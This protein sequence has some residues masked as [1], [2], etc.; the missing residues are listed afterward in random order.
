VAIRFRNRKGSFGQTSSALSGVTAAVLGAYTP[1]SQRIGQLAAAIGQLAASMRGRYVVNSEYSGSLSAS[2][3][4]AAAA[5][6]GVFQS[7]GNPPLWTDN[8]GDFFSVEPNTAFSYTFTASDAD[9]DPIVFSYAVPPAGIVI[10]EHPQVGNSRSVTVSSAGLPVPSPPAIPDSY[11][12]AIDSLDITTDDIAQVTVVASEA[13]AWTIGHAFAENDAPHYVTANADAVQVDVLNRWPNNSV[14]FALISAIS[15]PGTITIQA[16]SA[17]PTGPLV[18]EIEA[19]DVGETGVTID[20]EFVSLGAAIAGA[21]LIGYAGPPGV[22][23]PQPGKFRDRISGHVMRESHY[24]A[25]V[26]SKTGLAVIWYVRKYANG[27]VEVDTAVENG[28]FGFAAQNQ[29][30]TA[31][32]TVNGT[33]RAWHDGVLSRSIVHT[34]HSRWSRVD[35]AGSQTT[36]EVLHDTQYLMSTRLTPNY[37]WEVPTSEAAFTA[38]NH[39]RT[40]GSVTADEANAPTPMDRTFWRPAQAAGGENICDQIGLLPSWEGVYLRTGDPRARHAVLLGGR[41]WQQWIQTWRRDERT[42]ALPRFDDVSRFERLTTNEEREHQPSTGYLSYLLTGR[43]YFLETQQNMAEFN[44]FTAPPLNP[45]PENESGG[46]GVG[47]RRGIVSSNVYSTRGVAWPLRNFAN[48]L[49]IT[50]DADP[51]REDL[52]LGWVNTMDYYWGLQRD[53][54]AMKN[55]LGVVWTTSCDTFYS[56]GTNIDADPTTIVFPSGG[57]P[58]YAVLYD[59]TPA[60]KNLLGYVIL[61]GAEVGVGGSIQIDLNSTTSTTWK[62]YL[63][64][65][66]RVVDGTIN[67]HS[68][69]FKYCV[70]TSSYV[71]STS[72][73]T[74]AD[75]SAYRVAGTADTTLANFGYDPLNGAACGFGYL[76]TLDPATQQEG[77]PVPGRPLVNL[78]R[79]GAWQHSFMSATLGL[80]RG[81]KLVIGQAQSD[82]EELHAFSVQFPI[83]RMG[84]TYD[85]SGFSWLRC[86]TYYEPVGISSIPY[87][88]QSLLNPPASFFPSWRACYEFNRDYWGALD[89]DDSDTTQPIFCSWGNS[90]GASLPGFDPSPTPETIDTSN[91]ITSLPRLVPTRSMVMSLALG[92]DYSVPGAREAYDKL[93]NSGVYS[94]DATARQNL[95][96]APRYMVTPR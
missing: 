39:G 51:L 45:W 4:G 60:G 48:A 3:S 18:A 74:L 23:P 16:A 44:F 92:A 35:W 90:V 85:N 87:P 94:D 61:S 13:A 68:D 83:G 33:V 63:A 71:P 40:I 84:F 1:A 38:D 12:V 22:R 36:A 95:A 20:G 19:G 57:A 6:R 9:S 28:W 62:R 2:L 15:P 67:I 11:E 31:S 46:R 24:Y 69:T 79:I 89:I 93:M 34:A 65:E 27:Q 30:Y 26:T 86:G 58:M 29:T 25:P 80:A 88:S 77:D 54:T 53:N 82:L 47:P 32:V 72:H 78:V 56:D 91:N 49:C 43:C 10:T 66:P 70:V 7:S 96:N 50:P 37:G 5:M 8:L 52:A 59:D 81:Y 42:L 55:D 73:A 17:A 75:V 76:T 64:F 14:K 41:T 21:S